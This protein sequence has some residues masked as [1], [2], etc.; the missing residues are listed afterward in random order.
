MDQ[1][2]QEYRRMV[3]KLS[4]EAQDSYDKTVVWLCGG[5]LAVSLRTVTKINLLSLGFS[6]ILAV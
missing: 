2:W 5:A 6:D 4:Q 3:M 1:E